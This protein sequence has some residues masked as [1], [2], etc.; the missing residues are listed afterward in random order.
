MQR[1]PR[2]LPIAALAAAV[3]ALA[4]AP[5]S[6]A[7]ESIT[8]A[9]SVVPTSAALTVRTADGNTLISGSGTH[10]WTGSLTGTSVIDVHFAVHPAGKVTY[11]GFLT[12]TGTTPCGTATVHL[13]S[14]GSGPFPGPITGHATTIEQAGASVPLHA[15]LDVV[16]FLT[17]DGAAVTYSGDVRCG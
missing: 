16:L 10:A 8:V 13:V 14:F 17:P 9:G 3:F 2:T 4:A 15:Q 5:P 1:P 6:G 11:H 7:A 12:F